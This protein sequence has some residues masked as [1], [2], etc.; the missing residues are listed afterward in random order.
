VATCRRFLFQTTVEL[1]A[2]VQK[3]SGLE[4]QNAGVKVRGNLYPI[5]LSAAQRIGLFEMT[6]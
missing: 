5:R 1:L 6:S 3:M 4:I 2:R